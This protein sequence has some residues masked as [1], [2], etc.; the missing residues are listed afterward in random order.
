MHIIEQLYILLIYPL[1][2]KFKS[3]SNF[4]FSDEG[5]ILDNTVSE[6]QFHNDVKEHRMVKS[7]YK[8]AKISLP[9]HYYREIKTSRDKIAESREQINGINRKNEDYSNKIMKKV[10][11]KRYF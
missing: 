6:K 8:N 11:L 7:E 1:S 5:N 10:S 3:F 2:I 4:L 9:K